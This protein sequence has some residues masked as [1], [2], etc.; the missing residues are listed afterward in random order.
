MGVPRVVYNIAQDRKE[1]PLRSAALLLPHLIYNICEVFIYMCK[2][3]KNIDTETKVLG[4]TG[5]L[6]ALS[7]L[8]PVTNFVTIPAALLGSG[9]VGVSKKKKFVQTEAGKEMMKYY[10][11]AADLGHV[12]AK[13]KVEELKEYEK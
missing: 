4:R 3:Y 12:E 5:A 6:V 8:V 2:Y 7:V 9:M 11:R 1:N 10:H 13:K